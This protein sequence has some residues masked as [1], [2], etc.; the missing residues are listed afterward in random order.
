[1]WLLTAFMRN[2]WKTEV[3]DTGEGRK[4]ELEVSISQKEPQ[5]FHYT[6]TCTL[7]HVETAVK[8][9]WSHHSPLMATQQ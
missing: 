1:M 8:C 2:E 5:L 4:W 3:M 6:A 7:S 9:V